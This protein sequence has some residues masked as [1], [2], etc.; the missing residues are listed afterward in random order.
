[1]R[2]AGAVVAV[3]AVILGGPAVADG[4]VG[5]A[6]RAD[7]APFSYRSDDGYHGFIAEL[8]E[9]AV[10][11]A[12][13]R[14]GARVPVAA[15][16]RSA[17]RADVDLVCDPTTIT[18]ERAA[19]TDFSPI[20]FIANS[21]FLQ[22]AEPHFLTEAEIA[23]SD[24]CAAQH[25]ADPGRDLV[26]VGMVVNTT[27]PATFE[28]ARST[29]HLGDTM[30]YALCRFEFPSHADGI[31]E[32]CDGPLS[33]Y[34]GDV[35]IMQAA[36]RQ[37]PECS[38]SL[39]EDFRAYEPYAVSIPSDDDGFRRAFVAALYGLYADGS[40][41]AIYNETFGTAKMNEP[42]RLLFSVYNVPRGRAPD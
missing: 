20:L 22:G 27:A 9:Q 6:F 7:A 2:A 25:A 42:L 39:A 11:R 13:Y 28:L 3:A 21:S 19:R 34:F 23:L 10:A 37:H 41:L 32:I 33:F 26:G 15:A 1:M 5:V 4:E 36:L 12:G 16:D 30:N 35:D 14:I 24:D 38:A 18:L 17:P 8:C 29:G 40:A 31:A